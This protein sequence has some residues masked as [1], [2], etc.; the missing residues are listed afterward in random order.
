MDLIC[1]ELLVKLRVNLK[2][3]TRVKEEIYCVADHARDL[4]ERALVLVS[5]DVDLI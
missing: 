3:V 2:F 4:P 1:A 5:L